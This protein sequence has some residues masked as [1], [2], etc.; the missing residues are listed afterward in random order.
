MNIYVDEIKPVLFEK[1][2]GFKYSDSC[3]MLS[4]SNEELE[5]F[6]RKIKLRREWKHGDHYD[7]TRNKRR[8]AVEMGAIEITCRE[9]VKIRK[10]T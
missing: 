5:R 3:H 2:Q 8:Q 1:R 7:L 9:A 4:N 6:A 10:K